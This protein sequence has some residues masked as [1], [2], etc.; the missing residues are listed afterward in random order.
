[1][2]IFSGTNSPG[3]AQTAQPDGSIYVAQMDARKEIVFFN[4][5][6]WKKKLRVKPEFPTVFDSMVTRF[7]ERIS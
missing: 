2:Q 7:Q 6:Y 3:F 5:S 1:M 4:F